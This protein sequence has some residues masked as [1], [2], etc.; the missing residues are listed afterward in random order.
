MRAIVFVLRGGP[1]GWVGAYGN[2]WVGTPNLDRLASEAV[3]FGRHVSDCPDP[4]AARAA[5]HTG[6]HQ[7]PGVGEPQAQARG[8]SEEVRGSSEGTPSLALRVR[9]LQALRT[10]GV[11][12]VL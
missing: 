6:R 8:S 10:A 2:E 3:V 5:W 11:R 1:A 9:L 4:D 7:I 12:T